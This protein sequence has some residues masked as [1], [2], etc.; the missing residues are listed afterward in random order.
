MTTAQLTA[1]A[2]GGGVEV[3]WHRLA[4]AVE[5]ATSWV[6]PGP[7]RVQPAQATMLLLASH[8]PARG[9]A[10]SG[11]SRFSRVPPALG[12]LRWASVREIHRR[13]GRRVS[14]VGHSQG[15]D[16]IRWAVRWWPDV[17][18][19]V[20]DLV[21]IEGADRA[22]GVASAECTL[23]RCYPAAWQFRPGAMFMDALNRVPTP[24]GPSYTTIRSLTD[25]GVQPAWPESAA[26]G[27]IDGATNILV[28]DICPGRVVDHAESLVDAAE[29]AV[30]LDA[31]AHPGPADPARIDRAVCGQVLAAGIDPGRAALS[32]ATVCADALTRTRLGPTT[33]REPQL[34]PYAVGG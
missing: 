24:P 16:E 21:T 19:D 3:A 27:S 30:A 32:V 5:R 13:S 7:S 22:D 25:V 23:G 12:W 26:V 33:D 4:E 31:L 1:V 34:R 2:D 18:S 20:D 6:A 11:E 14:L 8:R 17:R 9:L 15:A 10:S 29:V 28:Q